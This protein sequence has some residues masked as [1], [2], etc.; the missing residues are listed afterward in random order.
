MQLLGEPPSVASLLHFGGAWDKAS[1]ARAA[2]SNPEEPTLQD[3]PLRPAPPAHPQ[4]SLV[5]T[6]VGPTGGAHT[7]PGICARRKGT[8]AAAGKAASG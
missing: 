7:R 3:G 4:S 8:E 1:D 6:G 5:A 2:A